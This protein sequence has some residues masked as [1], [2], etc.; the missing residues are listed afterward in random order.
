VIYLNGDGFAA[1]SY[2]NS[3][4]SWGSQDPSN[5]LKGKLIHPANINSS[6]GKLLSLTMHQPL[7]I[8]AWQYNV[9]PKIFREVYTAI[10]NNISYVIITWPNLFRDEV[11]VDN[12]HYSFAFSDIDK[13]E[14]PNNVKDAI[15]EQMK[16]FQTSN[17]LNNFE[18][19]INQLCTVLD[20]KRIKHLMI[21]SDSKLPTGNAN[22]LWTDETIV[23]W[24]AKNN[25]LN[26]FGFLNTQGHQSLFKLVLDRLTNQ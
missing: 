2:A 5:A 18:Q 26:S 17:A 10:E 15:F 4:F 19:N 7:R 25:Y 14:Y 24:A 9:H 20:S 11:L 8:E 3:I 12:V 13:L 23:S 22:W 16:L 1:A 21:P 6:F